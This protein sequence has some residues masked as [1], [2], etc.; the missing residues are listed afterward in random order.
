MRLR[1]LAALLPLGVAALAFVAVGRRGAEPTGSV[2]WSSL[3]R[4][5]GKQYV[6]QF[7]P[8][9]QFIRDLATGREQDASF[10]V[11]Y[12]HMEGQP[13]H[14]SMGFPAALVNARDVAGAIATLTVDGLLVDTCELPLR[15]PAT[16]LPHLDLNQ[17]PCD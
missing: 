9:R 8:D 7:G 3:S 10:P 17:K 13:S 11:T 2:V 15:H 5:T 4:S 1:V 6:V 12:G 14:L 16:Q